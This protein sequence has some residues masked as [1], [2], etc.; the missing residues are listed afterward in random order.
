MP[1][2]LA[3]R[4]VLAFAWA[5]TLA[6]ANPLQSRRGQVTGVWQALLERASFLNAVELHCLRSSGCMVIAIENSELLRLDTELA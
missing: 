5:G 2:G 3:L 4:L 1:R 6:Q